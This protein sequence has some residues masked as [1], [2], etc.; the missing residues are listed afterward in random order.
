MLKLKKFR[1]AIL[2]SFIS[3]FI[4]FILW[5]PV[6]SQVWTV[7]S[8]SSVNLSAEAFVNSKV[9]STNS[10]LATTNNANELRST[11]YARKTANTFWCPLTGAA[12]VDIF[13]RGIGSGTLQIKWYAVSYGRYLCESTDPYYAY[14]IGSLLADIGLVIS[15]GPIGDKVDV[16]SEWSQFS[17]NTFSPENFNEDSVSVKNTALSMNGNPLYP[18]AFFDLENRKGLKK[19]VTQK[20]PFQALVGDTVSLSIK[21]DT[22]AIIHE[23]GQWDKS[24]YM[25][26]D[27]EYACFWGDMILSLEQIPEH[28]DTNFIA[29]FSLDIGSDT[30]LSDPNRDGN[31]MFDPGDIYSGLSSLS[32]SGGSDGIIDDALFFGKDPYPD[33][34][35]ATP[36]VT[37]APAC[38][39]LNANSLGISYFDLDGFDALDFDITQYTYGPGQSSIQFFNS[40]TVF[41]PEKL[42]LSFDDDSPGHYTG[43][44]WSCEVPVENSLP[45]G[46]D[47]DN[48]ELMNL[49]LSPSSNNY[50]QTIA[51]FS[52]MNE[53]D[54]HSSLSPNPDSLNYQYND[55]VD[56]LDIQYD[57]ITYNHLYFSVDH[58]ATY[59]DTSTSIALDPGA[60][61]MASPGGGYMKVIDPVTH[62]GLPAG[63]DVDAFEFVWLYDSLASKD[64]LALL[65]STDDYDWLVSN[66][67]S[68]GLDPKMIYYSFLNGSYDSLLTGSLIDDDIDA[69]AA[70]WSQ[71]FIY[72]PPATGVNPLPKTQ[73]PETCC[74]MKCYPNPFNPS[75][76]INYSLSMDGK[77]SLKIYNALGANVFTVFEGNQRAGQYNLTWDGVDKN[78][79]ILPTGNYFIH[80]MIHHN[81][82]LAYQT[83]KKVLLIK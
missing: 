4:L 66:D 44:S 38:Q 76:H 30:E 61:Y 25:I 6:F 29:E 64:G 18:D 16:Y 40:S 43:D 31:E 7:S 33:P 8:N 23:P 56:A 36:P 42:I 51:L 39:T 12:N 52:S 71:P 24:H 22:Y 37:G 83:V 58:E 53:T 45:F 62:L 77:V 3:L 10:R 19:I 35:D 65:F 2:A 46:S 48:N 49:I 20:N 26:K 28:P 54:I 79:N 60:I 73:L 82:V 11:A 57:N 17:S 81:G 41:T 32:I 55:D 63:T 13:I 69:I 27:R 74:L 47:Y 21:A 80:L 67:V 59:V 14:G 50:Y 75:T 78:G 34:P 9:T 5:T 15:G 70:E 68:G 72:K 1:H